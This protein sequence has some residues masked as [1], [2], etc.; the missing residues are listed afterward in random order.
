MPRLKTIS[1]DEEGTFGSE[2]G[3]GDPEATELWQ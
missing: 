2:A 1:L 3:D